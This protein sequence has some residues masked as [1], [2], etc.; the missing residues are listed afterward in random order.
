MASQSS[1]RLF[2]LPPEIRCEIYQYLLVSRTSPVGLQGFYWE[3]T[4]HG[5][6]KYGKLKTVG[7]SNIH[8]SILRT[9]RSINYEATHYLYDSNAFFFPT[10]ETGPGWLYKIGPSNARTVKD[11]TIKYM[12]SYEYFEDIGHVFRRA[13]GLKRLHICL[14]LDTQFPGAARYWMEEFL[15]KIRPWFDAHET[16]TLA[17]SPSGIAV[18]HDD[19]RR[20]IA[21]NSLCISFLARLEDAENPLEQPDIID[22]GEE[23]KRLRN[24]Q[25]LL[26]VGGW[27]V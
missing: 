12:P 18:Q 9:C 22:I 25:G 1:S 10:D 7:P 16:L 24:G 14:D 17:V 2:C 6:H 11:M 15:V 20:Y 21:E 26:K 3:I 19:A 27:E 8:P 23:I 5:V 13:K 4:D